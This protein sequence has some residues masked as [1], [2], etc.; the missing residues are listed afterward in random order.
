MTYAGCRASHEDETAEIGGAFVAQ[1]TSGIDQSADTV[2]LDCAASKRGSPGCGGAGGLLGLEKFFLG[3]GLLCTVVRVTKD[4]CKDGER[5]GVGKDG[6]KRDGGW[7][8]RRQI[9]ARLT[10]ISEEQHAIVMGKRD[11]K[12]AVL[13]ETVY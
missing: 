1:G 3:I 2:R 5:S 12:Q 4:R 8:D 10:L 7:L 9:F 13:A 6:P 11:R